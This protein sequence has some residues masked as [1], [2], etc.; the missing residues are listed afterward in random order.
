MITSGRQHK[1]IGP[2]QSQSLTTAPRRNVSR[3]LRHKSEHLAASSAA[4]R[5][6]RSDPDGAKSALDWAFQILADDEPHADPYLQ[7]YTM[8]A[9][10]S[11]ANN[12]TGGFPSY[13]ASVE[14]LMGDID[15]G[16]NRSAA[17]PSV[18]TK[19]RQVAP[20]PPAAAW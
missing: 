4:R 15:A 1:R 5:A 9:M 20:A 14:L 3:P 19:L 6:E 13:V 18:F 12:P 8:S 11:S 7:G 2:H 10:A 16:G 17:V